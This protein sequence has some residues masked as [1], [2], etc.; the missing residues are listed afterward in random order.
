LG[1]TAGGGWRR[2]HA[3]GRLDEEVHVG[4]GLGLRGQVASGI[5]DLAFGIGEERSLAGMKVHVSL[6]Q[7]F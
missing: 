3:D 4:Y 7:R 6:L 5:F 2:T 1:F